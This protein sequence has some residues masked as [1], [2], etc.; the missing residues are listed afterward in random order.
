MFDQFGFSQHHASNLATFW[1]PFQGSKILS[2]STSVHALA[3]G[4]GIVSHLVRYY[5]EVP[6]EPLRKSEGLHGFFWLRRES[7]L[8]WNIVR[9]LIGS[10]RFD[11]FHLHCA[12]DPGF[13]PVQPPPAAD[14]E[15]LTRHDVDVVRAARRPR[16]DRAP[17]ERLFRAPPRGGNRAGVSRGDG[18]RTVRR[19]RRRPRR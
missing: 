10:T 4:F 16:R 18:S 17:S 6:P 13:P 5:P 3:T 9:A 11:S 19:R 1:E 8:G 7:E 15:A 12:G 2:F 14:L